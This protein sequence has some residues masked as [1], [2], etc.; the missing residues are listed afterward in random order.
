MEELIVYSSEKNRLCEELKS[1]LQAQKIHYREIN[2]R[3][4]EAVRTL[5]SNGCFSM[6]PPVIQVIRGHLKMNFFTNDDLF[7]DGKLVRAAIVDL[8]QGPKSSPI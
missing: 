5:R 6:E 8:A 4:P 3:H 1:A 2:I 7:W